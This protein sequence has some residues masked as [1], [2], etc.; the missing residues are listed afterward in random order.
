MQKRIV[1]RTS[2][3]ENLQKKKDEIEKLRKVRLRQL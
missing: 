2:Y 1:E 3:K